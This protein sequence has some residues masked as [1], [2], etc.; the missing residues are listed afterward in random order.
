MSLVA[1]YGVLLYAAV[2]AVWDVRA[3]R[4]PNWLSMPALGVAFVVACRDGGIGPGAA[5]AGAGLGIAAF[6]GPFALRAV[7]AGDVKFAAVAGAW[8]G[9]R[10]GLNALLLGSASGLFVALAF[11]AVGGRAGRALSAAAGV[12]W[13]AAAT[14]SFTSLPPADSEEERLAPIPYAL[15]LASGVLGTV[16]LDHLGWLPL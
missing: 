16:V 3:R 2:A 14:M 12:I 6:I 5:A 9:P 13:L 7:G 8:L 11:A 10:L 1:T 15:P 4:I